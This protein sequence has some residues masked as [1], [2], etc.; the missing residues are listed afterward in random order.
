MSPPCN[1]VENT[2]SSLSQSGVVTLAGVL[3]YIDAIALNRFGGT[4][5]ALSILIILPRW[6]DGVKGLPKVNKT[7]HGRQVVLPDLLNDPP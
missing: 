3:E 1:I 5:Y 4:S 6:M 2:N 7:E